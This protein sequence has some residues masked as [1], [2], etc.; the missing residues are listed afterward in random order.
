[1]ERGAL[2]GRS[3]HT[4]DTNKYPDTYRHDTE[5]QHTQ[6]RLYLLDLVD[7]PIWRGDP[8]TIHC[9]CTHRSTAHNANWEKMGNEPGLWNPFSN[10]SA[11]LHVHR[12]KA[13][14]CLGSELDHFCMST[15][16]N[17]RISR[18]SFFSLPVPF[19][20]FALLGSRF[21]HV[22]LICQKQLLGHIVSQGTVVVIF[23][24]FGF[25]QVFLSACP[26]SNQEIV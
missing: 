20:V 26:V 14:K 24:F 17:R 23:A 18:F 21:V 4:R 15:L 3:C 10:G 2:G 1:M 12:R 11:V 16:A 5:H 6:C 25:S 13:G 7:L 8:Q 9:T 19:S 22:L